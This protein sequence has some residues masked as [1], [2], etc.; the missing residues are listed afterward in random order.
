LMLQSQQEQTDSQQVMLPTTSAPPAPVAS[1]N[2]VNGQQ[3]KELA[4]KLVAS[5]KAE[6]HATVS[7]LSPA[8]DYRESDMFSRTAIDAIDYEA[9]G[10]GA[11]AACAQ[12][13]EALLQRL[14]A[15][16]KSTVLESKLKKAV[17]NIKKIAGDGDEISDDNANPDKWT[18]CRRAGDTDKLQGYLAVLE[19]RVDVLNETLAA[20]KMQVKEIIAMLPKAQRPKIGS[21][22]TLAAV[23]AMCTTAQ[24]RVT[25]LTTD[26]L[27]ELNGM[28]PLHLI[29]DDAL[30]KCYTAAKA[31]RVHSDNTLPQL[32]SL[33]KKLRAAIV[34]EHKRLDKVV[35]KLVTVLKNK[36]IY[37]GPASMPTALAEKAA[38]FTTLSATA[39]AAEAAAAAAEEEEEDEEVEEEEEEQEE[40]QEEEE[41]EEEDEHSTSDW[42][43]L[44]KQALAVVNQGVPGPQQ[45][46]TDDMNV[47]LLFLPVVLVLAVLLFYITTDFS[48]FLFFSF[49]LFLF[50]SFSLFLF[51]LFLVCKVPVDRPPL[52]QK[53][54]NTTFNIAFDANYDDLLAQITALKRARATR[55]RSIEDSESTDSQSNCMCGPD[56]SKFANPKSY[57]SKYTCIVITPFG[58]STRDFDQTKCCFSNC[59]TTLSANIKQKK[60]AMINCC[61]NCDMW[62]CH[63]CMRVKRPA[64]KGRRTRRSAKQG[65]K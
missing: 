28:P 1:A 37:S 7:K 58:D 10:A 19:A 29:P 34:A 11:I 9:N 32:L 21:S 54:G 35:A 39:A 15:L 3:S 38:L 27:V 8:R 6:L 49:S 30:K 53:I 56:V 48:L 63:D 45:W 55:K 44:R 62:V 16:K 5:E 2:A 60:N 41:E 4:K 65:E 18:E 43:T 59:S 50:F 64:K 13:K 42:N 20:A 61:D 12:A 24:T 14:S 51:S 46:T 26:A 31:N 33:K 17:E 40:E 47:C 23:H 36:N 22:P 57:S 52:T 25:S